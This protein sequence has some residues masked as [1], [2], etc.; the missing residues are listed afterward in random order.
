MKHT[1]LIGAGAAIALVF[2]ASGYELGRYQAQKANANSIAY[3]EDAKAHKKQLSSEKN[4]DDISREE[5]ISAEQIVV[6]ISDKGYVTS[7]GD[8]YHY[9]NGKVPYDALISE[10]LLMKDPN[11]VLKKSDIINAV[12]DGY[13]IKVDGNYYLYLKDGS[14]KNK[15]KNKRTN[16]RAIS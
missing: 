11:Y 12:K 14:K 9:Y 5:G 8:H 10:D 15:S 3:I 16:C 6:K 2:S 1:K 13:I 7:H 4:P